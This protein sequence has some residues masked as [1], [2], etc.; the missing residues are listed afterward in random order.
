[1]INGVSDKWY[2]GH[3]MKV[4]K[5]TIENYKSINK[6][7]V[8]IGD[9]P[10]RY[11]SFLGVNETGKTSILEAITLTDKDNEVT[12]DYGKMCHR[13]A[14]LKQES[15]SV[16]FFVSLDEAEFEEIKAMK[17]AEETPTESAAVSETPPNAVSPA[18]PEEVIEE[19]EEIYRD[20]IDDNKFI[21]LFEITH[22]NTP[23]REI[24]YFK[25]EERFQVS[26]EIEKY[27]LEKIPK[28]EF[29]KGRDNELIPDEILLTDILAGTNI[30]FSNCLN[31]AELTGEDIDKA[32]ANGGLQ[33]ELGEK[34][35]DEVTTYLNERWV[36]H[37]ISMKFHVQDERVTCNVLDNTNPNKNRIP[38]SARSDGFKKL[39][40]FLL[41][42]SV[43][44]EKG[45]VSNSL[46]LLDEP[47]MFL[48]PEAQHNFRNE[49]MTISSKNNN[50]VMIATHSMYM[51]NKSHIDRCFGVDKKEDKIEK[52][53][54]TELELLSPDTMSYA[55]IN[56]AIFNIPT[57][58]YH[59][60]LYGLLHEKLIDSVEEPD[61]ERSIAGFD[62]H[63]FSK[64]KNEDWKR[65][66]IKKKVEKEVT[67]KVSIHS[68]IRN[69]I[70]HPEN[71][72]GNKPYTDEQLRASVLALEAKLTELTT[73]PNADDVSKAD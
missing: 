36:G 41:S 60:E 12:I 59:N 35:S 58:E 50:V 46:L 53:F 34:L 8:P 13:P 25:N 44:Y 65:I 39:I 1:M 2:N 62:N 23:A 42:L 18:E 69:T 21:Y 16:E 5:I 27:I 64:E 57:A 72:L 71:N 51:I 38:P 70:H 28:V 20:E 56:F 47:E 63:Y 15:I 67:E 9:F 22:A 66:K 61:K 49:L 68:Y 52:E 6:I 17:E 30:P 29:W 73:E 40:S 11:I 3:I 14:Q 24:H 55:R 4:D 31:I 43:D 32:K 33:D 48:H 7:E 37:D 10:E 26:A 45:E 54:K 19:Q